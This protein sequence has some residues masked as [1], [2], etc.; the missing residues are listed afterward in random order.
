M[1]EDAPTI[2]TLPKLETFDCQKNHIRIY[3]EADRSAVI[4]TTVIGGD[5]LAWITY[6]ADQLD[7]LIRL[8]Q[9]HMDDLR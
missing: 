1:S 4:L 8:L 6:N 2:W 9:S 3:T 7:E 5:D